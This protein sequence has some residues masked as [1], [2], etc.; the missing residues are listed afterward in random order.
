MNVKKYDYLIVGSGLYGAV[1]GYLARQSRK[2][3]LVIEK[4]SHT[5]GNIYCEN[6]AGINVHKYGAHIFHT[7]NK[8]TWDFVNSLV[9][10][11]NFINSPIARYRDRLFNLPFNMNTFYAL[12]GVTK[13]DDARKIIEFQTKALKLPEPKNLEEQAISLVGRDIYEILIKDYTEKQWGRKCSELPAFIIKRL[14]VRFTFDN[15]YFNDTWQGIP[16]GGYNKLIEKLLEG[17]EVRTNTD[18]FD[19]RDYWKS[20]AGKI[21]F[22]GSIDKY[23]DYQFGRL[24]Y[25]TLNFE[26]EILDTGNYQGNAVVNYVDPGTPF[27]RIVEHRHFDRFSPPSGKTVITREYPAEW[28]GDGEPYYPVEDAKNSECYRKYAGYSK[29]DKDVIFGG[30]LGEYRYFDMDKTIENAAEKYLELNTETEAAVILPPPPPRPLKRTGLKHRP[31][32]RRDIWMR[33]IKG[34]RRELR[35]P[36]YRRNTRR[37]IN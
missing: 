21:V 33:I 32:F 26:T 15:N 12:W 20:T 18:F 24:E 7:S 4:R 13:P 19:N 6:I 16:Q 22:T 9:P 10:F 30:R 28:R 11:N 8:K 17:I 5:G 2:K 29:E 37:E 23:Y 35:G 36:R 31:I 25:R 14:P 1:F 3:V 34:V 27:T